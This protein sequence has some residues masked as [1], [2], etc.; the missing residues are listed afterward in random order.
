MLEYLS[1]WVVSGGHTK[2]ISYT[3]FDITLLWNTSILAYTIWAYQYL[4][5]QILK[6]NIISVNPS[7]QHTI[8]WNTLISSITFFQHTNYLNITVIQNL[9]TLIKPNLTLWLKIT[10]ALPS[11]K[12]S[13]CHF[14][15]QI[16]DWDELKPNHIGSSLS[17]AKN[18]GHLAYYRVPQLT[19]VF[20]NLIFQ[21][22]RK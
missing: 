19:M 15:F 8:F 22:L 14:V 3:F 4:N 21:V 7:F 2:I 16:W 9:L 11:S 6:D 20:F 1:N 10:L 5:M 17:R 13:T 18:P 12:S